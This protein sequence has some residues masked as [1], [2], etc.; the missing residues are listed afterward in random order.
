[1]TRESSLKDIQDIKEMMSKSSKFKS[2]SG[3]SG[4][5]AG[6][7]L[8]IGAFIYWYLNTKEI[9]FGFTLPRLGVISTKA[10]CIL[11]VVFVLSVGTLLLLT[12]KKAKKSNESVWNSTS[13]RLLVNFCI[14]FLSGGLFLFLTFHRMEH[15]LTSALM[16]LFYGLTLINGSKYTLGDIRTLGLLE[17]LTAFVNLLLPDYSFW[18]F[19]FGFGVLN[20]VYGFILHFKYDKQ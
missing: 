3:F 4:I 12:I 11:F 7:Y 2:I 1:M 20:I 17:I 13:K 6:C 15:S 5:F 8:L 18:I 19:I 16:L 10:I 14:P 9:T